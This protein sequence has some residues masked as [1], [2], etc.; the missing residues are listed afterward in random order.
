MAPNWHYRDTEP[1]DEYSKWEDNGIGGKVF[2]TRKVNGQL[3]MHWGGPC[4]DE[5]Y[6]EY[7]EECSGPTDDEY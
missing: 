1:E 2:V 6:D 7:G 5:Y 4:R 3:I